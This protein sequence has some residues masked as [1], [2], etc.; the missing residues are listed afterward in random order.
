MDAVI[1]LSTTSENLESHFV[2]NVFVNIPL[3]EGL[4][5]VVLVGMTKSWWNTVVVY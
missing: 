2:I 5:L 4:V 3:K 1:S